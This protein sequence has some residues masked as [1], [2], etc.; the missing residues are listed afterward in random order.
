MHKV[1]SLRG[2]VFAFSPVNIICVE[3]IKASNSVLS[4]V[5]L[6]EEVHG[7]FDKMQNASHG[8]KLLQIHCIRQSW[9]L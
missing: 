3:S 7:R 1:L 4:H 6:W 8:S 9:I 2:A 5:I